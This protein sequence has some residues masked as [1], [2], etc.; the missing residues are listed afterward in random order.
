[1]SIIGI[2]ACIISWLAVVGEHRGHE[3]ANR[4]LSV[5]FT[6]SARL[7]LNAE[8]EH[9]ILT[10]F[11]RSVCF[12]EVRGCVCITN[13]PLRRRAENEEGAKQEEEE[14]SIFAHTPSASQNNRQVGNRIDLMSLSC[15]CS[16][17][18]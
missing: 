15:C 16:A 10:H 18:T 2:A 9:E 1:M 17:V 4:R 11:S 13:A 3:D 14:K 6:S 8:V 5:K 12:A 7:I